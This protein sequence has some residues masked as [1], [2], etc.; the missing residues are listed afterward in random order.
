MRRLCTRGDVFSSAGRGKGGL[1]SRAAADV[2]ELGQEPGRSEGAIPMGSTASD[3]R[4]WRPSEGWISRQCPGWWRGE[5]GSTWRYR[6]VHRGAVLVFH[7]LGLRCDLTSE[8]QGNE[9]WP[10]P[11]CRLWPRHRGRSACAHV[12]SLGFCVSLCTSQKK[13]DCPRIV[14]ASLDPMPTGVSR[15]ITI[16][17]ANTTFSKVN[18]LGEKAGGFG[19]ASAGGRAW[20]RPGR[21]QGVRLRAGFCLG[22]GAVAEGAGAKQPPRQRVALHGE[23]E[24][25]GCLRT[26]VLRGS[27][28]IGDRCS[29]FGGKR[30]F[31]R[32]VK[33]SLQQNGWGR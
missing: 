17:L 14:P 8:T 11:R 32:R 12:T 27:P 30:R 25:G 23:A 1:G 13:I 10:G 22:S 19:W 33:Q 7:F 20:R 5:E 18:G 31:I 9:S 16:S 3:Q 2:P 28:A 6:S 26:G 24:G 29:A 4:S 21:P 15:D